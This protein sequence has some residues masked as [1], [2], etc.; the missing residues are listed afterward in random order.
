MPTE[1]PPLW[2]TQKQP[3][4]SNGR[5]ISCQVQAPMEHNVRLDGLSKWITCRKA[6]GACNKEPYRGHANSSNDGPLEATYNCTPDQPLTN[7]S[8]YQWLAPQ[9]SGCL[10]AQFITQEHP[11]RGEQDADK[12]WLNV[13]PSNQ[14]RCHCFR[15]SKAGSTQPTNSSI[16]S[17]YVTKKRVERSRDCELGQTASALAGE[18]VRTTSDCVTSRATTVSSV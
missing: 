3:K 8:P 5:P 2:H 9:Q 11:S 15:F 14:S 4:S 1:Y 6:D 13:S 12:P 18:S 7:T 17:E 16:K 10:T